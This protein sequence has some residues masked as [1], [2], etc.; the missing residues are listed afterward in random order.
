M[1]WWS[2]EL[3]E[4][5]FHFLIRLRFFFIN[6]NILNWCLL[7]WNDFLNRRAQTTRS[8]TGW[9]SDTL[10]CWLLL[11]R[12]GF[13]S[14]ANRLRFQGRWWLWFFRDNWPLAWLAIN[15]F[16]LL[17][18]W[19]LFDIAILF[20]NNLFYQFFG[21][22]I[23]WVDSRYAAFLFGWPFTTHLRGLGSLLYACGCF[24]DR[25]RLGCLLYFCGRK[26]FRL[27]ILNFGSWCEIS[28]SVELL[29]FRSFLSLSCLSLLSFSNLGMRDNFE[30]IGNVSGYLCFLLRFNLL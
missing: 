5:F 24:S 25:S 19:D 29:I 12:C 7:E 18:F 1:N 6:F 16:R 9:L 27:F 14:N 22:L 30:L 8:T 3:F 2:G 26:F 13:L 20:W 17:H 10:Y 28:C 15:F 23:E 4:R 11:W 21:G